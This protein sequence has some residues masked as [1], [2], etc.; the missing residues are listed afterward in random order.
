MAI[1][2]AAVLVVAAL[3]HTAPFP[4]LFEA[5]RP[6][7]SLWRVTPT[8]GAPPTLY[9]TFDDGPNGQATRQIVDILKSKNVPAT[10]FEVGRSIAADPS[11]SAYV[12]NAGFPIENHSW[13]HSFSLPVMSPSHIRRELTQTSEEIRV[14]AHQQP[15]MFRPPHGLRSPQLLYE[16]EQQHLRVV[17]WNLDPEDYNTGDPATIINRVVNHVHHGSI[18]LLHDGLQDGIHAVELHDR[19]GDIAALPELIDQVRAKGYTFVSLTKVLDLEP[20]DR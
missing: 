18:I 5:F 10:F 3:A 1:A 6:A 15:T 17:N 8:P 11:T 19:A 2:I 16:V 4:F 13:D 20:D 9:L 14:V 12:S 7:R